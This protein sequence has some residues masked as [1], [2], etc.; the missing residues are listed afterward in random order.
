LSPEL[1]AIVVAAITSTSALAV[2]LINHA[3]LTRLHIDVN[4]RLDAALAAQ[5]ELG[6]A[7]GR[8]ETTAPRIT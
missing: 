6:R 4:S 5:R 8:A 3:R 1:A 2:A 7:E